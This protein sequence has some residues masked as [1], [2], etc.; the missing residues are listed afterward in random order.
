MIVMS[1]SQIHKMVE[2]GRDLWKSFSLNLLLRKGYLEPVAQEHVQVAFGDLRRRRLPSFL[3]NLCLV[4]FTKKVFPSDQEEPPVFQFVPLVSCHATGHHWWSL[5][6]SSLQSFYQLSMDIDEISLSLLFLRLTSHSS[7][8]HS[9][10]ERCSSPL[11]MLA[12][13]FWI[14]CRQMSLLHCMCWNWTQQ[15]RCDF[16]SA[17]RDLLH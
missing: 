8:S 10:K 1:S 13:L 3:S 15:S 7:L 11:I 2:V 12:A 17:G 14:L 6:P 9:L 16:T 5:A 4:T